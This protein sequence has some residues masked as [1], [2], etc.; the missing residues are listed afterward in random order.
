MT[1]DNLQT[2]RD[3]GKVRPADDARVL[4]ALGTCGLLYVGA[5]AL[6]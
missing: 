2:L 5:L 1:G 3:Q 4:A 6:P